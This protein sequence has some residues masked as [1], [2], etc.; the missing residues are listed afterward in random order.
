M[1]YVRRNVDYEM[2]IMIGLGIV[3]AALLVIFTIWLAARNWSP[4]VQKPVATIVVG[5]FVVL[6]ATLLTVLR[7]TEMQ[8][9]FVS[10]VVID[11]RTHLPAEI[12]F[13]GSPI[14]DVTADLRNLI[15]LRHSTIG[16][17]AR[18]EPFSVEPTERS[19]EIAAEFFQYKLLLDLADSIG[20]D[21]QTHSV[22]T[23]EQG[24]NRISV[25]IRRKLLP[26]NAVQV[27]GDKVLQWLSS[28]RLSHLPV[29]VD[30]WK[31]RGM[32]LP[33]GAEIRFTSQM[34]N[35][36]PQRAFSISVAGVLEI[37]IMIE[38]RGSPGLG[39]LPP[40]VQVEADSA[41]H[42]GTYSIVVRMK[43]HF[44]WLS[45]GSPDMPRYKEWVSFVFGRIERLN[46]DAPSTERILARPVGTSEH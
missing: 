16:W 23:D 38:S 43:A 2:K 5:G 3:G 18:R 28:N 20:T 21:S 45:S 33:K 19:N 37:S 46:S 12:G 15:T 39:I 36:M 14:P 30:Q 4:D 17:L 9:S 42:F 13:V 41:K 10:S 40:A 22:G 25:S 44:N 35:T 32:R 6:L 31:K 7:P 8:R 11:D 34:L 29:E 1:A 27:P 26:P 24:I